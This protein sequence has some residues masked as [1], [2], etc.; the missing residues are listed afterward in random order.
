MKKLIRVWLTILS[1]F[2]VAGATAGAVRWVYSSRITSLVS[3]DPSP[4][5]TCYAQRGDIINAVFTVKN[6]QSSPITLLGA[7]TSCS[8]TIADGLPLQL[9]PGKSGKIS[10][11]VRVKMFDGTGKF[12]TSAQ[13]LTNRDGVVP[14]LIVEA[15]M[16]QASNNP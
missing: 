2:L 8:C 5:F 7:T 15:T 11:K 9:D 4:K 6:V 10:L 16:F 13:L 3:V 1:P 12:S 14:P